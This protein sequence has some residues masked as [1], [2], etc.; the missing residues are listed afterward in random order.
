MCVIAAPI[1]QT[2]PR[3]THKESRSIELEKLIHDNDGRPLNMIFDKVSGTWRAVGDSHGKFNNSIGQST[4]DVL[5]PYYPSWDKVPAPLKQRIV[6]LQRV[7][8]Y[9]K[10]DKKLLFN[11]IYIMNKL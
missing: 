1:P 9:F 4:R 7:L 8:N 5:P 6:N 10:H 3:A 2:R 11:F